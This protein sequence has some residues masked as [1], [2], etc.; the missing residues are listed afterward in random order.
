MRPRDAASLILVRGDGSGPGQVLMGRRRARTTFMP[1]LYVFPGGKVDAVDRAV[2][3]ASALDPEVV[4]RL[5]VA[6]NAGL[7]QALAM[8][9]V[10][11]T[12]EETGL[13]LAQPGDLGAAPS[14]TW[15]EIRADGMAPALA[16]LRYVARAI[17]PAASPI[18]FHARFF[19]ADARHLCG[20]LGGSGELVDL[21]WVP[22]GQA[23]ELPVADVTQFMLGEAQRMLGQTPGPRH[24]KILWTYR[25]GVSYRRY[26]GGRL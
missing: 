22:W 4:P 19:L 25:H 24:G 8:A 5:A 18:R 12:F 10:R 1:G 11:E 26:G 13:L 16:K 17:T 6:N 21:R 2:R 23:S 20:T 14:P 9:A 3:P 7:A 15:A